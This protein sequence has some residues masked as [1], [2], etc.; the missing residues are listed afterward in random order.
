MTHF[1]DPLKQGKAYYARA[2]FWQ[3]NNQFYG[4]LATTDITFANTETRGIPHS[5]TIT[6]E[7][8]TAS[9]ALASGIYY[10]T[11]S[12]AAG[13]LTSTG[14]LVSGGIATLDVPRC[15]VVTASTNLSTTTFTIRGTDGYGAPLTCSFV[16]PTGDTIGNT[17]S[18][19][20][21]LS[22][23]KTVTTASMTA[24]ATAGLQI[25]TSDQY[26]LP[27]RI[28]N[29]GKGLDMYIGGSSATI[30]ATWTAGFTATGT[31]TATTADVRG[32]VALATA[33][34]VANG[35]RYFTAMFIA[36]TVGIPELSDTTFN[37]Y[38]AT[39]FST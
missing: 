4:N 33:G 29:A 8:G 3:P 14:V 25:G 39:P 11:A 19:T 24:I 27:F 9:T 36:P 13:T 5:Q 37:S 1:D 21:S 17:G 28:A 23:F 15:V 10:S 16:G 2:A 31:T 32:I 6:Y 7:L 18:R 20:Y 35:T 26:G 22:A 34:N 38:G 30:P 12:T